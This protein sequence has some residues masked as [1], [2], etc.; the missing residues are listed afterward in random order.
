M[1]GREERGENI[2]G[3]GRWGGG[4]CKGKG[5]IGGSVRGKER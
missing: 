5:R 2:R 4:K 1:I 3:R